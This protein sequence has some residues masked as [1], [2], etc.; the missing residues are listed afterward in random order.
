[1]TWLKVGFGSPRLS[2]LVSRTYLAC[3]YSTYKSPWL[4]T[5]RKQVAVCQG[6]DCQVGGF[7]TVFRHTVSISQSSRASQSCRFE[8]RVLQDF[9]KIRSALIGKQVPS[10]S[11]LNNAKGDFV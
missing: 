7:A 5:S 10:N 11:A 4:S 9:S 1:M 6:A 8:Y 2:S 3:G